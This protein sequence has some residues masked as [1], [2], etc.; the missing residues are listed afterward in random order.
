MDLISISFARK[1][2]NDIFLFYYISLTKHFI[3][4]EN[5]TDNNICMLFTNAYG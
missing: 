4:I 2:A 1:D 5:I 3:N